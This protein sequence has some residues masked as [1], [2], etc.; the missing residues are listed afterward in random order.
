MNK[1]RAVTVQFVNPHSPNFREHILYSSAL[2]LPMT[3]ADRHKDATALLVGSGPSLNHPNVIDQ[4]KEITES[5]RNGEPEV[6]VYACKVA[7]SWMDKYVCTPSYGV[8]IDPGDHIACDEKVPR[9]PGVTHLCA[10]VSNPALFEW[11]ADEQVEL[12]NSVCGIP[13]EK[14]LYEAVTGGH[15]TMIGGYNVINRAY[16][17][18]NYHGCTKFIFAG[19]DCGWRDN[20]KMYCDGV[21]Y[22]MQKK[23]F[24][25]DEGEIDGEVW[26]STPDMVASGVALAKEAKGF[27]QRGESERL[28]FIGDVL[29][30]T[31]RQK[32]DEYLD[33]IAKTAGVG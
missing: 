31:L 29:P 14:M 24:I 32:P 22:M 7:I 16:S 4:L 15:A 26:H 30:A 12:F 18:A 8:T 10:T 5:N 2:G 19:V 9:V 28:R 13:Y 20:E 25:N 6:V 27:D 21:D 33:N 23:L 3:T 1:K 11:L 17:V